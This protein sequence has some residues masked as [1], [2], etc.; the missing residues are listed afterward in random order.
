MARRTMDLPPLAPGTRGAELGRLGLAK[1]GLDIQAFQAERAADRADREIAL[2]EQETKQK[3]DAWRRW[4]KEVR[5]QLKAM[6]AL[7]GPDGEGGGGEVRLPPMPG[8]EPDWQ[9]VEPAEPTGGPKGEMLG[10]TQYGY[11]TQPGEIDPRTGQPYTGE[12]PLLTSAPNKRASDLWPPAAPGPTGMPGV[13]GTAGAAGG[14]PYPGPLGPMREAADQDDMDKLMGILSILEA[15]GGMPAPPQ[16]V[17]PPPPMAELRAEGRHAD[18]MAR[19]DFAGQ[20]AL[21]PYLA[22]QQ[23][24]GEMGRADQAAGDAIIGHEMEKLKDTEAEIGERDAALEEEL[25]RQRLPDVRVTSPVPGAGVGSQTIG[26]GA[27]SQRVPG[28]PDLSPE[29]AASTGRAGGLV[30][31]G[32][33]VA[34]DYARPQRRQPAAAQPMSPTRGAMAKL[35]YAR[36]Q[37]D[38]ARAMGDKNQIAV[39]QGREARL[40]EALELYREQADKAAKLG[41]S[42]AQDAAYASSYARILD[43]TTAEDVSAA[44]TGLPGGVRRDLMPVVK[45]QRDA[46]RKAGEGWTDKDMRGF[47]YNTALAEV[48]DKKGKVRSTAKNAIRRHLGL[49]TGEGWLNLADP[50][51]QEHIDQYIQDRTQE[52][53]ETWRRLN[54]RLGAKAPAAAKQPATKRPAAKSDVAALATKHGTTEAKLRA[55]ITRAR[56]GDKA[57]QAVLDRYGVEY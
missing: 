16:Q 7:Q 52:Y 27:T 48:Y 10:P 34:D 37:L 5:N 15:T 47:A 41:R 31:H 11:M 18:D 8:G 56:A 51:G 36:R 13:A 30:L 50:V 42:E 53:F 20:K 33:P 39:W 49:D 23:V 4:L 29:E 26:L 45:A 21:A 46:I 38:K 24:A 35:R 1:H 6:K 12:S 2:R 40:T 43:A 19:A 32:A 25:R 54:E 22:E 14:P 17:A 3:R 28:Y 55:A 9:V 57:A 44:T